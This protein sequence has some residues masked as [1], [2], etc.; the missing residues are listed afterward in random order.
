MTNIKVEEWKPVVGFEGLY[1]VSNMG[2]VRSLGR[3]VDN[4]RGCYFKKG[5][6][7]KQ[8]INKNGRLQVSLFKNGKVY[9]KHT[10]CLVALSFIGERP[11]GFDVCHIDGDCTNNKLSNIRYDT[12]SQNMIDIYRHGRK[13]GG[14]K[15]SIE[16][17]LEIRRLYATGNY[18]QRELAEKFNT[19]QTN[20]SQIITRKYFSWL[21][22]D[23][24]IQESKSSN[25]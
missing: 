25:S 9:T 2:R 7:L 14:G 11:N 21:N 23:G 5:R 12:V 4:G 22:D 19:R 13:V 8:R 3:E 17:V 6:I 1:E 24:T 10:H 20:I 18:K 16:Q 15:L